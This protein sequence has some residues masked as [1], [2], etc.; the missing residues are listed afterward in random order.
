MSLI[1]IKIEKV[2]IQQEDNEKLDTIIKLL[3][4]INDEPTK[5]QIMDKL[6]E[7]I[8]DLKTTV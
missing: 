7:A 6:V 4:E 2:I 5:Q 1:T 3:K 8:D